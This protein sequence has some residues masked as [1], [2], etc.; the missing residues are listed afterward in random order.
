MVQTYTIK[1]DYE[2]TSSPYNEIQLLKTIKALEGRNNELRDIY[3]SIYENLTEH[4][5]TKEALKVLI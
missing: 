2:N 5:F 3:I 4:K 1:N